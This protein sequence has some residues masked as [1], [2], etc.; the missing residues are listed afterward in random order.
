MHWCC[1]S[2]IGSKNSATKPTKEEGDLPNPFEKVRGELVPSKKG[3][4][5]LYSVVVELQQSSEVSV[6]NTLDNDK[7]ICYLVS[8]FSN[9]Q[10]QE[11]KYNGYFTFHYR[12]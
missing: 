5:T 10:G 12:N 1:Q 9:C 3:V 7:E 2:I 6:P 11:W 4:C 8:M